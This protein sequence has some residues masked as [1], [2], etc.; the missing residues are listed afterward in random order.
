MVLNISND[1]PMVVRETNEQRQLHKQR[2]VDRAERCRLEA[3]EEECQRGPRPRD[4]ANTFD[5]VGDRQIF[6]SPSANVAVAMANLDRL[7]DQPEIQQVC[8]DIRAHL[9]AAMGQTVELAKRAHITSSTSISSS[10]SRRAS[11]HPSHQHGPPPQSTL[12]AVA[13]AVMAELAATVVAITMATVTAPTE[14]VWS[15]R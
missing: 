8:D 14:V 13:A 10:Q 9:I 1:E 3:E 6:W 4:L 12:E 5:R 11:K 2:N 15:S 7:P